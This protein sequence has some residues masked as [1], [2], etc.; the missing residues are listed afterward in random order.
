MIDARQEVLRIANGMIGR[1]IHRAWRGQGTMMTVDIGD[2]SEEAGRSE[3]VL[4]VRRGLWRVDRD[5]SYLANN[6][7]SN[8]QEIDSVLGALAG[9]TVTGVELSDGGIKVQVAPWQMT[10]FPVHERTDNWSLVGQGEVGY[11]G[12]NGIFGYERN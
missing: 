10:V 7:S 2:W 6:F 4:W 8:S 12:P 9:Q 1:K 3:M 5:G 11:S